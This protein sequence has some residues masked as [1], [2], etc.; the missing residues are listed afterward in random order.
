MENKLHEIEEAAEAALQEDADA[1]YEKSIIAKAVLEGIK[2]DPYHIDLEEETD[3]DKMSSLSKIFFMMLDNLNKK[4]KSQSE[5]AECVNKHFDQNAITQSSISKVFMQLPLLVEYKGNIYL[6]YKN[7]DYYMM[8]LYSKKSIV[9]NMEENGWKRMGTSK[10][11]SIETTVTR[12]MDK[13]TV[14]LLREMID[15]RKFCQLSDFA[16]VIKSRER[17]CLYELISLLQKTIPEELLFDITPET[18]DCN[19]RVMLNSNEREKSQKYMGT[20]INSIY[21]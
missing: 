21:K 2:R 18:G 15:I 14:E 16:I 5:I 1:I 8:I 4:F 3:F 6:M 19:I 7:F 9:R 20:F 17:A 11:H 12:E 10:N 13:R